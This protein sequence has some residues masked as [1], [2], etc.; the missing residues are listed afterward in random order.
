MIEKKAGVSSANEAPDN[1]GSAAKLFT[2]NNTSAKKQ[3]RKPFKQTLSGDW[4]HPETKA[5]LQ[6]YFSL[7]LTPIPLKGKRPIVKWRHGWNPKTIED[8]MQFK[9]CVNWGIKTGNNF[10]VIDF[11]NPNIFAK[12]MTENIDRLP[13]GLPLI[14][15][16]RGYHLWFVPSE[17][18]RDAHFDG[19]DLLAEGG[20]ICAPPSIHPR[21]NRPYRFLWS[22][23]DSIP[24]LDLNKLHFSATKRA[25]PKSDKTKSIKG[26][27]SKIDNDNDNTGI[28]TDKPRF[29]FN[30]IRGG[31]DEG[32]RH[33][34]LVS[35]VGRLIWLG[36]SQEEARVLVSDWNL[37]NRPPLSEGEVE[38]TLVGCYRAYVKN[39]SQDKQ[40]V[41]TKTLSQIN[42]V[43]NGTKTYPEITHRH[44]LF[45]PESPFPA[46]APVD[47][48]DPANVWETENFSLPD[49]EQCG[50]KRAILRRG[51]EYMSVSF[52][53]GRW[54]CPR[55]GP[56]FRQR[57]I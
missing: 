47:S 22:L 2:Y 57:W 14:K 46:K 4:N 6:T 34:A 54:S 3:A 31:V 49:N 9:D 1:Q 50:K 18:L 52:F 43:L 42:S 48:Q 15:S 56:F 21:T 8:V 33:N 44:N 24:K 17:P 38:S 40:N 29:D 16:G 12:F 45:T 11:D 37:R 27:S 28:P 55:C 26:G 19:F 25:V 7:G 30:L 20:Q 5:Q 39:K 13:E 35:Y 41:P 23:G 36:V 53:C 51:R 32:G 10:A